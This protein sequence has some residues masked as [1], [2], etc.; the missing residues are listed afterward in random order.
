MNIL[1]HILEHGK[2]TNANVQE[3]FKVSRPTALRLLS[4]MKDIIDLVGG[5]GVDSYYV[6]RIP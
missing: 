4:G 3:M 2:I 5:K 1:K 6:I